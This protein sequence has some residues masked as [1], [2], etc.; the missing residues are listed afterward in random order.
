MGR[1]G[2]L[3]DIS[4][5]ENDSMAESIQS[6]TLNR[7]KSGIPLMTPLGQK[8]FEVRADMGSISEENT[9]A[10]GS[11]AQPFVFDVESQEQ[12]ISFSEDG[13]AS[14]SDTRSKLHSWTKR[15]GLRKQSTTNDDVVSEDG[16]DWL[17]LVQ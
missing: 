3:P 6:S 12:S 15:H 4:G 5:R 1:Y 9:S 2:Y 7:R 11:Q 17:H 10:N 8:S 13:S 16:E 14:Q